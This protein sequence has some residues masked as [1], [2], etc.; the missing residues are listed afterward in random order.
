MFCDQFGVNAAK[1]FMAI[2]DSKMATLGEAKGGH[3][4]IREKKPAEACLHLKHDHCE[5]L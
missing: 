4:A 2:L 5:L 1:K 3:M